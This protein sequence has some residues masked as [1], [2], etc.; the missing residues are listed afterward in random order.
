MRSVAITGT[1]R[2]L[3]CAMTDDPTRPAPTATASELLAALPYELHYHPADGDLVA[4]ALRGPVVVFTVRAAAPPCGG[5]AELA[6]DI[7]A[8]LARNCVTAVILIGYGPAER[9][10]RALI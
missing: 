8:P 3:F 5:L 10:E 2:A 6:E 7:A 1:G 4:V 9:I